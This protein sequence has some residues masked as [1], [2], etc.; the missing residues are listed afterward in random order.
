MNMQV[1][2]VASCFQMGIN[3][4]IIIS[5]FNQ[6]VPDE[7]VVL[8]GILCGPIFFYVGTCASEKLKTALE[9]PKFLR[10]GTVGLILSGVML[11]SLF[12]E[13]PSSI[14]YSVD[15]ILLILCMVSYFLLSIAEMIFGFNLKRRGHV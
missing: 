10:T 8:F 6:S 3:I 15:Q 5:F 11:I 1:T 14:S 7:K 2:K 12:V 13:H 4:S 9:Q